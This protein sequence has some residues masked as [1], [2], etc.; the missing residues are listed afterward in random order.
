MKYSKFHKIISWI[1]VVIAI[2]LFVLLAKELIFGD[3]S[4]SEIDIAPIILGIILIINL[5]ISISVLK[6]NSKPNLIIIIFQLVIITYVSYLIYYYNS[7]ASV[8]VERSI[9]P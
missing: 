1:S 5:I 4:F 2:G 3:L 9:V 6:Q 7:G 8:K